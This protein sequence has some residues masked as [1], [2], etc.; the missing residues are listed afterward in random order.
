MRENMD[1]NNSEYGR[2]LLSK[3]ASKYENGSRE[4]QRICTKHFILEKNEM[5]KK[6]ERKQRLQNI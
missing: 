6:G 5:H 2:F 4:K 3:N 1:Q